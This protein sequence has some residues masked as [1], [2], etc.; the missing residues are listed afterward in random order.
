MFKIIVATKNKGKLKEI[1]NILSDIPV[2]IIHITQDN[3]TIEENG[4]TYLENA[5]KKAKYYAEKYRMP[6]LADDS[7]LEIDALKGAPGIHSARFMGEG[8]SFDSKIQEIL[9]L[10]ENTSERNARFRCV[11]VL[12]IPS[13]GKY[14]TTEGVVEGEILREPHKKEGSGF[15]YDPIF[16]PAGYNESF[17]TLGEE[18]KNQ[19]SHRSIA[20]R[21]MKDIILNEV[22]GGSMTEIKIN[23]VKLAANSYVY[24]VFEKVI[25]ALLDTLNNIP[26]IQTVEIK[27]NKTRHKE[28]IV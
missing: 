16:K 11:A 15:G 4:N 9:R 27:I 12:Y 8:T 21:K 17:S 2:R 28:K 3:G 22:L 26:E 1:K 10:M 6:A 20:L 18:I 5:L 7:G 23:G 14:Y 25:L 19:I 13:E 24:T